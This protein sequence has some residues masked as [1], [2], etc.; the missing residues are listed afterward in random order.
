MAAGSAIVGLAASIA[1]VIDDLGPTATFCAEAGCQTVRSSDWAHPLGIPMSVLGVAFF[2]TMV[3]LAFVARPALRRWLA[4]AGAAWA[5]WLIVLQAFV[6]DAWCKLCL[7]ADPSAIVHAIAVVAG[8][9]TLRPGL[10]SIGLATPALGAA[11]LAL[12][13]WTHHAPP[14]A[15]PP[16]APLPGFV[17]EAQQPGKVTIVELVD[18]ECPFCREMQRRLDHALAQTRVPVTVVRKMVPLPMHKGAIPA[19]IAWC[20]AELQ[21]KGDE[22]AR[23]LFAADPEELTPAGCQRLAEQVGCDMERFRRD[24]PAAQQRAIADFQQAKDAGIHQ[25]PTLFIG[26]RRITGASLTADEL[27][28]EIERAAVSM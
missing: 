17:V 18:F 23:A 2:A 21:G 7:V 15:P 11:V 13:L 19:A 10:R 27:V 5:V 4:I 20:C 6:I 12:A 1:S 24:V 26:H 28:T 14:P 22:M 8:A 16:D 3:G 25:L 9:R